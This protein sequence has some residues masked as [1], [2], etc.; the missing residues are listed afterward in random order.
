MWGKAA[1]L[2]MAVVG[3]ATFVEVAAAASSEGGRAAV[4]LCQND[5]WQVVGTAD[6]QV[7]TGFGSCVSYGVR[8]GTFVPLLRAIADQRCVDHR[9][10]PNAVCFTVE[11]FGL[12]PG[13]E[14]VV[15]LVV[16]G[17]PIVFVATVDAQGHVDWQ[18]SSGCIPGSEEIVLSVSAA[19][20]TAIGVPVRAA[21]E[22]FSIFCTRV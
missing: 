3:A 7:F 21:E 15:T 13:S 11:G 12:K 19:G 10:P 22:S 2:V 18:T 17:E 1:V 16:G 5:G 14:V 6:E 8:G 4:R 20:I 9:V